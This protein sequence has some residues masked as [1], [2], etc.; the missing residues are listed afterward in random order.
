MPP[1]DFLKLLIVFLRHGW[2]RFFKWWMWTQL[3]QHLPIPLLRLQT[4]IHPQ[5]RSKDLWRWTN[6]SF[7]KWVI[8]LSH[9]AWKTKQNNNIAILEPLLC[10]KFNYWFGYRPFYSLS[11]ALSCSSLSNPSYGNVA[12]SSRLLV[13]STATYTCNNGYKATYT[14]TRYCQADGQWSGGEPS[15]LRKCFPSICNEV[16]RMRSL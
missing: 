14:T 15:C 7:T 3:R 11:S 1:V 10:F 12:L 6:Y 2:V 5:G 8:F 16:M 9:L 4:R 13:G